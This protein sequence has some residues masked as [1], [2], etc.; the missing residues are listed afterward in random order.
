[1]LGYIGRRLLMLP[2]MLLTLSF[3]IFSLIAFLRPIDRLAVFLPAM[4]TVRINIPIEEL[5]SRYELDKPMVVQYFKW[6]D[7]LVHGDMGW[8]AYARMPVTTAIARYFPATMELMLLGCLMVF[9]VAIYLGTRC[10]T[11]H[12]RFFDQATR[13]ATTVGISLP[14]F[15]FGL[16]LLILF[17][18]WLGWFPPGRLDIWAENVLAFTDYRQFTGMHLVDSLLNRRFDIFLNTLRHMFLPALAY[19][20]G[21]I[22]STTRLLRSS[23]LETLHKEYVNT[24]RA[25]GLAERVVVIKHARRNALL[26]VVTFGGSIVAKMLGGAVVVETVFNY[27]GM[28]LFMVGAAQSLDFASVIGI[29]LAIGV[30]IILTNLFIDLL[31]TALDPTVTLR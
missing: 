31:Y 2:L 20:I 10:A 7:N 4:D 9:P 11:H 5:I 16:I 15:V 19:S 23:L 6:L 12:N 21:L 24:A 18:V 3:L 30:L 17:Y 25:K 1:M 27:R 14:E 29:S 22:A 26:P 8:S 28:G 13:V